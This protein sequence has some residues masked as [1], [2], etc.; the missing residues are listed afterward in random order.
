MGLA[1]KL[2]TPRAILGVA[3]QALNMLVPEIAAVVVA[4]AAEG[5]AA[6]HEGLL[7]LET[8]N[9]GL[10]ALPVA[11]RRQLYSTAAFLLCQQDRE[12]GAVELLLEGYREVGP[13]VSNSSR[14]F[15]Q[16]AFMAF[17]KRDQEK[18]AE[19]KNLIIERGI[20]DHQP[21]L[22][23][24][25]T[26]QLEEEY[27]QAAKLA[28][29]H[30]IYFAVAS[31]GAFCWL[32]EG[33][34]DK[35]SNILERTR[36]QANTANWWLQG[37]I[38][39]SYGAW[40]VYGEAMCLASGRKLSQPEATTSDLWVRIWE[41][42]P[43]WIGIF[44]AF[45]FPCLPAAL[46]GLPVDLEVPRDGL[47]A[48]FLYPDH[49]FSLDAPYKSAL[50]DWK[51]TNGTSDEK[52]DQ[53]SKPGD[54]YNIFGGA[55]A[56]GPNASV[57][58]SEIYSVVLPAGTST[59]EELIGELQKVL[60]DLHAG[61]QSAE[62]Q[63]AEAGL[64]QAITAVQKGDEHALVAGLKNAGKWALDRAIEIGTAIAATALQNVIGLH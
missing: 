60:V 26:Y 41:E 61:V 7:A 38:A 54:T 63:K 58:K 29:K 8:V 64:E 49:S 33:E 25:L 1:I 30:A 12:T 10:G 39:A 13:G 20:S 9:R 6:R 35:A 11:N 44:P 50:E 14:L 16:A 53:V 19:I 3:D 15:E 17:R 24:V 28:E 52:G 59:D 32:V 55:G 45:Y 42:S 48:T 2:D 56:V 23:D 18:I 62:V 21:A 22:C 37:I 57:E 51:K 40:E 36:F 34:R 46:T 47:S 31:Q 43:R 5:L 4:R 27:S